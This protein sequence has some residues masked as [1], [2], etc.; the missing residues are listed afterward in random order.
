[1][2]GNPE[3]IAKLSKPVIMLPILRLLDVLLSLPVTKCVPLFYAPH[4]HHLRQKEGR[5]PISELLMHS[6][7]VRTV[8]HN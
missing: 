3:L 5:L 6:P 4:P 8:S 1:M 2:V 7:L